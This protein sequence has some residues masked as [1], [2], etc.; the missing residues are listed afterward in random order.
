MQCERIGGK[1]S[2]V[3]ILLAE[4]AEPLLFPKA[5]RCVPERNI[6]SCSWHAIFKHLCKYTNGIIFQFFPNRLSRTANYCH[7][8]I[9]ASTLEM[10]HWKRQ[11]TVSAVAIGVHAC[12]RKIRGKKDENV[13]GSRCCGKI[14]WRDSA[15][16]FLNSKYSDLSVQSTTQFR[17]VRKPKLSFRV[18]F[19]LNVRSKLAGL[20]RAPITVA[21]VFTV[22]KYSWKQFQVTFLVAELLQFV[23]GNR[24]WSTSFN[25]RRVIGSS[26]S[27]R[28]KRPFILYS[29]QLAMSW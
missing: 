27:W 12:R 2:K 6:L 15:S 29:S 1:Q 3:S 28:P 16:Q 11:P 23:W 18:F 5:Q 14:R 21:R 19:L 13:K 22:A 20:K 26:I 25:L 24:N 9:T 17:N 7:R 10:W 8:L 4:R